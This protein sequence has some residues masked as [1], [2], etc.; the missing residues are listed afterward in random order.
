MSCVSC[1]NASNSANRLN[2]APRVVHKSVHCSGE[3]ARSTDS[4]RKPSLRYR[5]GGSI[6]EIQREASVKEVAGKTG[7]PRAKK[8]GVHRER[9]PENIRLPSTRGQRNVSEE[10][11][12]RNRET[13]RREQLKTSRRRVTRGRVCQ[14]IEKYIANIYIYIYII[15]N[16]SI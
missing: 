2:S 3:P 11:A 5:T 1:V 10:R 14:R 12:I 16:R 6:R 7:G 4:S 8:Q 9:E 13:S 15:I